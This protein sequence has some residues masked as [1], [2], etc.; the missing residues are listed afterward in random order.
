MFPW[1]Q[2]LMEAQR[3]KESVAESSDDKTTEDAEEL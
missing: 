3:Q 2:R 1:L